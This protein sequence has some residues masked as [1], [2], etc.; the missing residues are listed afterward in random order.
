[1]EITEGNGI[2]YE[3]GGFILD[4]NERTLVIDDVPVH[5]PAK[6]FD[7]LLYLVENNGRALSKEE[8][9]SAIWQDTFVE[10]AN[11]AKH[12]SKLRKLLNNG[13]T[14]LI[15]TIPKHGYRFA[16]SD[17]HRREPRIREPVQE[18]LVNGVRLYRSPRI[19]ALGVLALALTI[20]SVWYFNRTGGGPLSEKDTIL[21]A[22][23]ENTTG[24]AVFDGT[25]KQALAIQLEQ[26]PFLNIL[27]DQRVREALRF[28]NRSPDERVTKD[29]AR[30]ICERH[31][32]KAY[33]LGSVSSLGSHFVITLEAVNTQTGDIIARQQ[34]QAESKEQVISA[35]GSAATKLRERLGESLA[36]I[37]K[38]D[39]PI[40]EV[41][42]SS[43]E[44][45][46]AFSMGQQLTDKVKMEES[47]PFFV[48]AVELDP[49]FA[50]AYANLSELYSLTGETELGFQANQKAFD[51]RDRVSERERLYI[52]AQYY[53]WRSEL[54]KSL[55]ANEILTRIYP[56]SSGHWNDLGYNYLEMGR[57]DE[58][59]E[60]F[61]EAI[62]LYPNAYPYWGL[63][64]ALTRLNRFDEAKEVLE[65]ALAL[66]DHPLFHSGLYAIAFVEADA[67]AMQLQVEW[68][69]ARPEQLHLIWQGHVAA[70]SGQ[71]RKARALYKSVIEIE[72]LNNKEYSN[73][74]LAAIHTA[75]IAFLEASTGNCENVTEDT[76]KSLAIM[77]EDA[78][79]WRSAVALALCGETA[80]AESLLDAYAE[81]NVKGT[82]WVPSVP[83]A[84]AAIEIRRG[85]PA[86]AIELLESAN[87]FSN[88]GYE[89]QASII[90]LWNKYLRGVAHLD[91]KEGSK[92]AAEFQKILDNRGMVPI[93]IHYPLAHLGMARAAFL[94]GDIMKARR[95]YLDFLELW[96][97]ADSDIPI[98]QQAKI[99]FGK[100]K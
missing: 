68:A 20:G 85:N 6:E 15:Q 97:D 52:I 63:G 40:Q 56:R 38:Y 94:S 9:L 98:L 10:E 80:Q 12:I 60:P 45:L 32:L 4:P 18:K 70:F 31:G 58:A 3:F 21:L 87:V 16:V 46:K 59:V 43:L 72:Q 75:L 74:R 82:A 78:A 57:T 86:G 30:E 48:R 36:S 8:M 2:I 96:K 90:V 69:S 14:E 84:R 83:T 50:L 100:L 39:A 91:Q 76:A 71:L 13:R 61:R 55:E 49:A 73:K 34:V 17:L 93:S 53:K 28:M 47:I 19:V 54:E 22:D 81:R 11:L 7:T 62:R 1:M 44:A 26:S 67:G 5:L 79:K 23:F 27:S 35:L 89:H 29:I 66:S 42:T 33:L 92:A 24:D 25:L 37:E 77:R 99:E 64:W 51:L 95:Y 41:T 88:D 65:Q